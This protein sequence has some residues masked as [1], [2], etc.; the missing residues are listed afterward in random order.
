M[1]Y[2]IKHRLSAME[3]TLAAQHT[4]TNDIKKKYNGTVWKSGCAS[5]YLDNN[6]EVNYMT[7][8]FLIPFTNQLT[9]I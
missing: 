1:R 9:Y 3:P 4:Y 7:R 2:A 5:W 6:G 8:Y